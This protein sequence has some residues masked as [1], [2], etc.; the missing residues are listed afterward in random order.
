MQYWVVRTLHTNS[1]NSVR[2]VTER[3]TDRSC[4]KIAFVQNEYRENLVCQITWDSTNNNRLACDTRIQY[5]NHVTSLLKCMYF[6]CFHH[7]KRRRIVASRYIVHNVNR[8]RISE[9][10]YWKSL[11]VGSYCNFVSSHSSRRV[12]FSLK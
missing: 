1:K 11:L 12:M 9:T 5:E 2:S 3:L 8:L 4:E 7:F 6:R 10:S